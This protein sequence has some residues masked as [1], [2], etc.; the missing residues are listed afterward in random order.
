MQ[1]QL[2]KTGDGS[3]SFYLP[4]M[5]EHYHSKHGSIAE[6]QHIFIQ[7]ALLYKAKETEQLKVFEVGMG[8]GLNVYL[9]ALTAQKNK[10]KIEMHSIEAYPIKIEEA[11]K[12]N[13]AEIL[14]ES[15]SIFYQ[16]HESSW[17]ELHKIN[18]YFHLLKIN[19]QLENFNLKESYDLIY[20]DAFAPEKQEEL[21]SPEIFKKL[22]KAL[23]ANGILVTYC[24]KGIIRRRLQENGFKIEKL[25]GPVGGKREMLRAIKV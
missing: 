4:E 23:N 9:T 14:E 16:I 25:K 2:V 5:D 8:T 12:L 21:W 10:L 11:K 13:Y 3:H 18:N 20:F 15:A 7:S 6:S 24:V 22:Y 19:D 17:E 1:K